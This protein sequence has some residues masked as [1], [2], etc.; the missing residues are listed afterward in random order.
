MHSLLPARARVPR[1]ATTGTASRAAVRRARP[2]AAPGGDPRQRGRHHGARLRPLLPAHARRRRRDR[3]ASCP[4][5]AAGTSTCTTRACTSTTRTRGR[6]CAASTRRYDVIFV[7][8]YR[9]PYIPFYLATREF[10]EPV[11]RPADPRRRP[12]RERRAP[13][14]RGRA[15]EGALG[16]DGRGVPARAARPDRGHQHSA[17]RQRGAAVG[18]R[19]ARVE[20]SLPPALRPT[21]EAAARASSARSAEVTSTPTTRRRSSG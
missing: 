2:A 12:D 10:F 8:A 16:D 4:T 5:S 3:L 14:G 13:R 15:R 19:I 17:D 7:D 21:G 9:Q 11:A 18:G 6:S 20:P 1:P